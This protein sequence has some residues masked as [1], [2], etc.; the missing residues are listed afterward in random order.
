MLRKLVSI[1]MMGYALQ[2]FLLTPIPRQ[3]SPMEGMIAQSHIEIGSYAYM[4]GK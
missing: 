4:H 1:S 2:G 3:L